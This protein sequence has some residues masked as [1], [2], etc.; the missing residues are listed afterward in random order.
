MRRL[1]LAPVGLRAIQGRD[2]A[3][4]DIVDVGEIAAQAALIEQFDRLIRQHRAGEQKGCHIRSTPRAIDREEAQARGGQPE[5]MS[6]AVSDALIC[7]LGR[8]IDRQRCR[9]HIRLAERQFL[10][11]AIDGRGGG[12]DEMPDFTMMP[13][14]FQH[15]QLTGHICRHIA[16]GIDQRVTNAGLCCQMDDPIDPGMRSE[17]GF[18]GGTIGNVHALRDEPGL[19]DQAIKPR[20]FEAHVI[21]GGEAVNA[22]D[23]F[24]AIQQCLAD[25]G[26]DKAGGTGDQNGHP[27]RSPRYFSPNRT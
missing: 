10:I 24:P 1:C 8:G 15:G 19:V 25:M 9:G 4:H 22:E 5:Q 26:S 13:T 11:A 14:G 21:I 3:G 7:Q 20:L 2:N 12:V 27:R 6:I 18:D 16:V 17:Q 23:A